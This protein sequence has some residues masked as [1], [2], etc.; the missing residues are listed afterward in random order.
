MKREQYLGL[1]IAL[2]F[3]VMISD[4]LS[5]AN[6]Y[7]DIGGGGGTV[8]IDSDDADWFDQIKDMIISGVDRRRFVRQFEDFD[9]MTEEVYDFLREFLNNVSTIKRIII[10]GIFG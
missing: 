10:R 7:H 9:E 6:A 5:V 3:I 1:T 8:Y 4:G 2:C